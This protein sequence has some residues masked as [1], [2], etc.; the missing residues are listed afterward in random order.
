[1]EGTRFSQMQQL[2]RRLFAMRNGVVAD[3]LR[4]A[5]CP[6]RIIFGLNLP[7]LSEIAAEIGP[8]EELAGQ[9]WNDTPLRESVLL[10]PM[11]YPADKL[12]FEKA[13]ELVG[14]VMWA[15]DADILCFKLLRKA[16]FAPSLAAELCSDSGRLARYTGLRLYFTIVGTCPSEAL[17]ASEAEMSRPDAL[18]A[19]ASMLGEEARFLMEN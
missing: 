1:M 11:I 14:N 16:P 18:S 7:Q 9:L 10:A 2:K 12:T 3:S 4:R 13:R 17:A 5:G 19:L 8:S 15:E 6:H